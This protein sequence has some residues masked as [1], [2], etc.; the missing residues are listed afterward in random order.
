[1]DADFLT[2]RREDAK[3]GTGFNRECTQMDAN[4]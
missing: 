4:F 2:Q 1:M 3:E